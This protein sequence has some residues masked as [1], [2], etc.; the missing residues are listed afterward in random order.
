VDEKQATDVEYN[1]NEDL[2]QKNKITKTETETWKSQVEMYGYI[3]QN[4]LQYLKD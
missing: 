3:S 1:D 4:R 2:T